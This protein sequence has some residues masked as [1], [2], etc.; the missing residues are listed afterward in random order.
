MKTFVVFK[1]TFLVFFLLSTFRSAFAIDHLAFNNARKV[2]GGPLKLNTVYRFDN[3]VPNV[4]A[5]VSAK[6]VDFLTK[7]NQTNVSLTWKSAREIDFNYYELEHSTDGNIFT[8]TSIVF[9]AATSNNGAEY[10]YTD[11][12]VD[13]RS[14]LIYYRLK[15]VD[16]NGNFTYSSVRVVSLGE[17][18][19]SITL[20]TYPNPVVNDLRITLPS[21]WQNKQVN[22]DLYNVKGQHVNA[23]KHA[24]SSQ[25]ES[26]S[27]T[28]LQKGAYF[29][30][31][32]C[33]GEIASQQI[34]KN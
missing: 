32:N 33:G 24:N 30:K 15:M 29:V 28:G 12:S 16:I 4:Y 19:T 27:V 2:S 17:E 18:K 22:I 9:G 31:A 7:Y 1:T 23:L 21:S 14:G 25:T 3:V 11:K 34:I 26:I 5:L 6:L 20:S 10:N 13:G 8:T